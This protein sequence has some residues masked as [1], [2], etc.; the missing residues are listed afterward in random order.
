METDSVTGGDVDSVQGGMIS[1][2]PVVDGILM[3]SFCQ[4]QGW[5]RVYD[6]KGPPSHRFSCGQSPFTEPCAWE[7]KYCILTDSQLILLNKEEEM[8]SEVRES[9]TA[10]SSK[11]RS[12]R[13]TVS[14]PSEGQFPEYPPEGTSML[15]EASA[16]R[17]P[18]RRSISG[19]HCN[20]Q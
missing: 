1:L 2:D 18:R 12:L 7:R 9:P 15:A 20:H 14:V 11:V 4:Q 6:V 16:E 5:V 10:S 8:P 17:S 19:L 3:D 13:R